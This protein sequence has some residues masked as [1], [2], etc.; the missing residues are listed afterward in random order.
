M[1]HTGSAVQLALAVSARRDRIRVYH[2]LPANET[3][4]AFWDGRTLPNSPY[5]VYVHDAKGNTPTLALEFD[6]EDGQPEA[7][8]EAVV[9]RL[10]GGGVRCVVCASGRP[11]HRHVLATFR[12]ALTPVQIG[13][14]LNDLRSIVPS[15]DPG[16]LLNRRT[17]A[18]RPPLAPHRLGGRSELLDPRDA[19][20]ALA[21]LQEPNSPEGIPSRPR[22][23]VTLR[24]GLAI[25]ERPLS[26][27]TA[28]LLRRGDTGGRYPSRSEAEAALVLGLVNAGW[29]PERIQEAADDPAN[30]GFPKYQETAARSTRAAHAYL[31]RTITWA[32]ATASASP[33]TEGA[34]LE[35]LRALAATALHWHPGGRTAAFDRT[36][37]LAHVRAALA[38]NSR[39]HGVSLRQCAEWAGVADNHTIIRAR[40]RLAEAGWLAPARGGAGGRT[41]RFTLSVPPGLPPEGGGENGN[42]SFPHGRE[43]M[44]AGLLT[45][46]L[47]HSG[48]LRPGTAEVYAALVG[49]GS[50]WSVTGLA[51]WLGHDRKTIRARLVTLGDLRLAVRTRG[52]W[53]ATARAPED[54]LG[55]LPPEMRTAASWQQD[56]HE[57]ERQHWAALQRRRAEE[58]RRVPRQ[59]AGEVS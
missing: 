31:Q 29:S 39:V 37:L 32:M 20:I 19:R 1:T 4:E 41:G 46:D 28:D 45:P 33:P 57:A 24:S 14:L 54:A 7:D 23:H 50:E 17:G 43:G 6:G 10:R 25:L 38:A 44:V 47:F 8:A 55:E 40:R 35:D 59:V 16:P 56:R 2:R 36:V 58:S 11:G 15:L 48:A 5:A 22:S 42:H 21:I 27:A 3:R 9:A 12:P 52:G 26:D 53:L 51:E 18:I 49:S 13:A 30:A 34:I